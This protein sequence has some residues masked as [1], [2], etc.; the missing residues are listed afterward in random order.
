MRQLPPRIETLKKLIKHSES[1]SQTDYTTKR[2][3]AEYKLEIAIWACHSEGLDITWYN[4]HSVLGADFDCIV[5]FHPSTIDDLL[6]DPHDKQL[7][8]RYF[9]RDPAKMF[10]SRVKNE[11]LKAGLEKRRERD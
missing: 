9:D 8:R 4:L 7:L 10:L 3:I 2:R 11:N 5:K 1:L 6:K